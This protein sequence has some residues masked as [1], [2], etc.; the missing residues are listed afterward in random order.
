MLPLMDG[1]TTDA[2]EALRLQLEWGADEAL[3]DAPCDRFAPAPPKPT[4]NK[5]PALAA[6]P[7]RV[8]AP[9]P[10]LAAKAAAAAGSLAALQAAIDAFD[11]CPLRATASRTVAPDGNAD[12]G[13]VLVGEAPGADD[14]RA[15]RAFSGAAGATLDRVLA[16]AGLARE[17]MLLSFLVPWRPPGGRAPNESEI[18]A[19][20]PF[21]HRLL[22]LARPR[23]L[24]LLGAGPL[25]ALTGETG[26]LRQ[27]RGRWTHAVVPGLPEP[28]AA[29]PM[30][31]PELWLKTGMNRQS[32]WTD[33]MTLQEALSSA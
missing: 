17:A 5:Q 18:A 29:L 20:L 31:A 1:M 14:D 8:L 21:M 10:A 16:S 12:A 33:L 28:V 6:A 4:P 30:L 24:V 27:A 11:H 32:A 23:R 15:G 13:L 7:A 19:C 3:L 25:R 2:L 22:A 9:A 26:G